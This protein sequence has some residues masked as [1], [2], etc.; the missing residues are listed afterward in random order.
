MKKVDKNTAMLF[1]VLLCFIIG[2]SLSFESLA[3]FSKKFEADKSISTSKFEVN[4]VNT[5]NDVENAIPGEEPIAEDKITLSNEND[6]PVEFTVKLKSENKDEYK[7]LLQFLN[8]TITIDNEV[9]EIQDEYVIRLEP[10][11]VKDIFAKIEWRLDENGE[12][13]AEVASEATAVYSY[14]I[15]AKQLPNDNSNDRIL[16]ESKYSDFNSSSEGEII[17]GWTAASNE[18]QNLIYVD[19]GSLVLGTK[20]YTDLDINDFNLNNENLEFKINAQLIESDAIKDV[21]RGVNL[22]VNIRKDIN[23]NSPYEFTYQLYKVKGEDKVYI[24]NADGN[25]SSSRLIS[26]MQISNDGSIE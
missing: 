11:T 26:E 4:A 21:G 1:L 18:K 16:Y 23:E 17:D 20:C 19:N 3:R 5:F 15:K 9:K 24:R 8:L 25:N 13:D 6:Y 7:N 12:I 2:G 22:G 14:D 10:N